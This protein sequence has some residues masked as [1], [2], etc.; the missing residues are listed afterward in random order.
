MPDAND[1]PLTV[2][3]TDGTTNVVIQSPVTNTVTGAMAIQQLLENQEW[4]YQS[5]S[6]V[7][8]APHLQKDPLSGV[9]AKSVIIQFA[10]GDQSIEN[11][12]TTAFLRAGDLA[13]VATYYRH[14]LVF[15]DNPSLPQTL[16]NPHTF[17]G[18]ITNAIMK[19][20]ALAAQQQIAAFF[21]ADGAEIIQPPGVS[22]AYFEVGMDESELPEGLNY[23][24]AAPTLTPVSSA[25]A[26]NGEAVRRGL[27]FEPDFIGTVD[28]T[29]VDRSLIARGRVGGTRGR[30]GELYNAARME[31]LAYAELIDSVIAA[32]EAKG[33]AAD[34]RGL[35]G[36]GVVGGVYSDIDG[37]E[38]ISIDE[39]DL[40]FAD[41][42]EELRT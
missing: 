15:A 7:A 20:V 29:P 35:A 14:D 22:L 28:T 27:Y 25:L 1:D 8:Y 40:V 41:L 19:P 11:P 16:W 6:A 39:F 9:P 24:V 23:T 13:D 10:K 30:G 42:G 18:A 5:G 21:A 34:S 17:L 33:V 32:H 26:T 38:A 36:T 12:T 3:L 37:E 2:N 31:L 4:V